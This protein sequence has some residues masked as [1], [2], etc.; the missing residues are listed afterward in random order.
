[1]RV[2]IGI[3]GASGAQY[4][5]TLLDSLKK[6]EVEVGLVVSENGEKVIRYETT[7]SPEDV[8]KLADEVYENDDLAASVSSGSQGFEAFV[9]VPCSLSTLSKV[10]HGIADNLITRV[11]SICLKERRML[12]LVPRET[13]LSAI[14]L[15]NMHK[16]SMVGAVILPAMPGF[17]HKPKSTGDLVNFVVGKILE[18]LGLEHDL[19]ESWRPEGR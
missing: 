4:A 6:K 18:Q 2:I 3:T 1:M 11:A 19:Y 12:I 10:A 16:L 15:E 9:V 17:Y 5:V 14:H 13:P 8:N 7:H